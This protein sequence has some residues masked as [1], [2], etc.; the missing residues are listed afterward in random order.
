MIKWISGIYPNKR[1]PLKGVTNMK[2]VRMILC[3][4]LVA[5]MMV[6]AVAFAS[7]GEY[8]RDY[9]AN[10]YKIYSTLHTKTS[11]KNYM[12]N[13]NDICR[14]TSDNATATYYTNAWSS[15]GNRATETKY[16]T[17][18][19]T[20]Y[21]KFNTGYGAIDASYKLEMGNPNNYEVHMEG[22]WTPN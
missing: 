21:P 20:V 11:T 2:H 19:Q 13:D 12:T 22:L 4:A 15:G 18:G 5:S 9:N 16:G 1:E 8:D 7:T 6:T 10:S 17:H 3:L 14:R